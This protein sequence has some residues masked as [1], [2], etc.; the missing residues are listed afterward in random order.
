MP[1]RKDGI[2]VEAGSPFWRVVILH[3]FRKL[4]SGR[5]AFD[6]P[7]EFSGTTA[8]M[9]SQFLDAIGGSSTWW[10]GGARTLLIQDISRGK[11]DILLFCLGSWASAGSQ[12]EYQAH[13]A[14]GGHRE[15][16]P[17]ARC[18]GSKRGS[19]SLRWKL[20]QSLS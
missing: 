15:T 6:D 5:F 17:A 9:T 1:G 11:G 16:H 4:K 8:E 20:V 18:R 19:K 2:L 7:K 10:S 13:A 3:I 12:R 14:R